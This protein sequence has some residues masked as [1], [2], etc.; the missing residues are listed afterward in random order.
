MFVGNITNWTS[1]VGTDIPF[2]TELNTNNKIANENGSIKLKTS[3]FWNVDAA[4]TLSG[5]TGEIIVSLFADG[6]EK[7]TTYAEATLTTAV[8]EQNVS[9]I[10]G[11]RT[12]LREN[13]NVA[14]IS[15]RVDTAGVNVS[16]K[17]RVEYVQ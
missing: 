11:I 16:G 10:D 3:G 5:T 4:L 6:V 12:I 13:P 8:T 2:V 1:V 15:L 17:I 7:V 14:S 9:I